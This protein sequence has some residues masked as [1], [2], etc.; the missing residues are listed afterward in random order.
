MASGKTHDKLQLLSS[1]LFCG[2]AIT[3]SFPVYFIAGFL[4][5][6]FLVWIGLSPDMDTTPRKRLGPLA[7]LTFP[8]SLIFKHRGFSHWPFLGTLTRILYFIGLYFL[9]AWIL[10]KMGHGS[11]LSV[12][13]KSIEQNQHTY[14]LLAFGLI[15]GL[16]IGDI[17]HLF[18][19]ILFS[20]GKKLKRLF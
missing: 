3:L 12:I 8:Y 11:D 2:A 16:V 17:I 13:L 18:L 14:F 10:K 6:S 5:G 19:D 1:C 9:I 20:F 7:I 15:V 4:L